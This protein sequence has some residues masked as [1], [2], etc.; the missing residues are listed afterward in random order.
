MATEGGI[1]SE[2]VPMEMSILC[3]TS[4]KESSSASSG[5]SAPEPQS[6][7]RTEK[8]VRNFTSRTCGVSKSSSKSFCCNLLP[9]FILYPV[10]RSVCIFIACQDY[11]LGKFIHCI[12]RLFSFYK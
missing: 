11:T 6:F 4:D 12:L 3:S 8:R 1:M 2:S 9:S 5:S 10:L 7:L